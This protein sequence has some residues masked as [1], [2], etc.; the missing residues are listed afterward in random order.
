MLCLQ[1]HYTNPPQKLSFFFISYQT[2]IEPFS[3]TACSSNA[4]QLASLNM[5]LLW[6][7]LLIT[8]IKNNSGRIDAKYHLVANFDFAGKDPEC[9]IPLSESYAKSTIIAF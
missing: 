8:I 6:S 1:L 5:A 4:G 3:K 9:E 7:Y 2:Q